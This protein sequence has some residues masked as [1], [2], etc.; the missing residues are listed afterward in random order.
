MATGAMSA[1][2]ISNRASPT[3]DDATTDD[4]LLEIDHDADDYSNL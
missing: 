2:L 4:D 1:A 3:F